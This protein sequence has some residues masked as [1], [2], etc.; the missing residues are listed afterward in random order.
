L[1]RV[2]LA[3]IVGGALATAGATYQGLF[4]NPLSV[5]HPSSFTY[6]GARK[7]LL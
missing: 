7:V 6:C 2:I 3:G 5:E 1:P 4:P